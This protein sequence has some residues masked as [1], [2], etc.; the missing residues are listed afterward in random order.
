MVAKD[1]ECKNLVEYFGRRALH[2]KT[3]HLQ[4]EFYYV[5]VDGQWKCN[6]QQAQLHFFQE[7]PDLSHPGTTLSAQDF[8]KLVSEAFGDLLSEGMCQTSRR[9]VQKCASRNSAPNGLESS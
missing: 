4:D 1:L 6:E 7:L 9:D 8:E 2:A 5:E 3:Y